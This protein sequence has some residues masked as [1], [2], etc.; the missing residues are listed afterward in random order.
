MT[1][2]PHVALA[3]S[4]GS[5]PGVIARLT[6]IL[7]VFLHGPDHLALEDIASLS[8]LPKSTTFRLLRQL[9]EMQWLEHDH[10]GY[11]LGQRMQRIAARTV[12]HSGL[13]A[14]A[15][16]ELNHL[17]VTTSAVVHLVVLDGSQVLYL[18]KVGGAASLS[19]PSRVG[20]RIPAHV[21]VSGLSLLSGLFPE[22]VDDLFTGT[23]LSELSL[24]RL[25]G[26]LASVRNR[27]GVAFTTHDMPNEIRAVAAPVV[28]PHGAVAAISAA[29]R[30]PDAQ[31]EKFAPMVAYAAKRTARKL[32][33]R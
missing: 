26:R 24:A 19:I 14:A 22:Q 28:G 25:H 21:A 7:D 33:S 17:H 16:N 15:A 9:V 10:R 1:A 27:N 13:R 12:D 11:R 18:D 31:V 5:R 29:I 8:G 20:V 32:Y 2:V 4:R 6:Q 30:G 23:S 3:E